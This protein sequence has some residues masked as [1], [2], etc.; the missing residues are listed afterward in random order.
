MPGAKRW[1]FTTNNPDM[2]NQQAL[3]ALRTSPDVQ[4]LLFQFEEG[5]QQTVHIQGAVYFHERMT[6]GD[7]CRR[8]TGVVGDAVFNPIDLTD[9]S[10]SD[11]VFQI[12]SEE[13]HTALHAT[14]PNS[15]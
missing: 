8:F 4:W 3:E 5:A 12:L 14:P 10:D 11:D 9:E 6:L 15:P 13:E 1:V 2:A 7:V